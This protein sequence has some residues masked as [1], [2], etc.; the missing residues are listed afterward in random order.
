MILKREALERIAFGLAYM[1]MFIFAMLG[2]IPVLGG[3]LKELSNMS[4]IL[5]AILIV[6]RNRYLMKKDIVV[7]FLLLSLSFILILRTNYYGLLK[8]VLMM[9]ATKNM[10]FKKCVKFD[11]I[12]RLN[13]TMLLF[14]LC[15]IGI[16]P[17]VVA[18]YTDGTERH[19][20][21]FQNSNNIGLTLAIV[22]FEFLYLSG[23]KLKFSR[24]VFVGVIV[25]ISAYVSGG[26]TAWIMYFVAIGFAIVNTYFAD[27][28]RLKIV[29]IIMT[30]SS[31]VFA[32][33]TAVGAMLYRGGSDFAR[34]LNVM[35]SGR[36]GNIVYYS[37]L[38]KPN[39]FGNDL[40]AGNRTL[41]SLY[42]YLW[43]S[44]G[45]VAFALYMWSF[46]MLIKTAYRKRN[47]SGAIIL[48][49]FALYGLSERLWMS[50]D[51]NIM[52]LMYRELLYHDVFEE[53]LEN[54]SG[55]ADRCS[56]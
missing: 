36:I 30:W 15:K 56:V 52:M 34:L 53:T 31:I 29:E 1:L 38:I 8:L 45:V 6:V 54:A 39:L 32:T 42:A 26:R 20:Y 28:C 19:S 43:L 35:T 33:L 10:D 22:L 49:C 27:F 17:D 40:S 46:I 24:Y 12:L 25:A 50:I 2:H 5:L 11:M 41:D 7:L 3:Y 51:Y 23:M 18:V 4:L 9:V 47:V 37:G 55:N 13:I 16:A 44:L 21:G 48:F 14:Y